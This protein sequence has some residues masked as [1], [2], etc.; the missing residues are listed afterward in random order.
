MLPYSMMLY[1]MCKCKKTVIKVIFNQSYN[2][3][4]NHYNYKLIFN[5]ATSFF[6]FAKFGLKYMLSYPNIC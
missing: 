1:P 2:L 6:L 3:I 5:V 4:K